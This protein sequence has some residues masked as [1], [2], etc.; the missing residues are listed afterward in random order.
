MKIAKIIKII[1]EYTIVINKGKND[2]VMVGDLCLI[3]EI[4]EELFDIDSNK[5]LGN[6]EIVK[7]KGEVIHTQEQ[8]STIKSI[9]E[10]V[11]RMIQK[12]TMPFMSEEE[13]FDTVTIPF[14]RVRLNDLVKKIGTTLFFS[15]SP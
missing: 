3:Y 4:G 15:K 8:M 2:N 14:E 7:G 6:L 12:P 5:S 10:K 9:E 13:R 1:D 11:T